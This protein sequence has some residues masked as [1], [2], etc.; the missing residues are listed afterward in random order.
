MASLPLATSVRSLSRLRQIVRVL[1]R[2]GFGHVVERINLGRF[3]PLGKLLRSE[4]S[5]PTETS[6]AS[7]GRRLASVAAELGP[8]FVKLAQM[9]STRPD[10][11]SP[12]VL[13][14]LRKLQDKVP[15]FDTDEAIRLI[16]EQ[17]GAPL[18]K[19]FS[20]FDRVPLASGSIG[21]VHLA[22]TT[23]DEDVVVK[24]KR[25]GIDDIV[26][27]DVHLLKWMAQAGENM[28][29][30]LSRLRPVQIVEEFEQL[31]N[32]ELDF[33]SEASATSR[34]RD[35]FAAE[36]YMNIPRVHWD[37]TGPGVLTM[38]RIRGENV[39]GVVQNG[40]TS[41]DRPLLA[42]RLVSIYLK[43]FFDMR[44]F[45]ADPHPGNFLILPPARIGL[46]DFGQVGTLSDEL[47]GQLVIIIVAMIYREP[48]VVVDVLNDL[49]AVGHDTDAR[50][51]ARA[52]RSLL[53]KYYG[54]P[55][56][57]LDLGVIFM[58]I[59]EVIRSHGV[60]L[61]REL[62]TVLKTLVTIS[63]VA[64]KLDP[65]LN[66]VEVMGPHVRKL[67]ADRFAPARLARTMTV[68]LW[69][70]WNILKSAPGQLRSVLRQ[71][72]RGTWQVNI[73]HENLDR[74]TDE[75][76]RS[77]NRMAFSIVIAA[78]IVGSSVVISATEDAVLLGMPLRWIGVAGYL[79]AGVLGVGLLWAIFRSGRLS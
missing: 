11:V 56:K 7:L 14:E 55:L 50:A 30:E 73:R 58:E 8:T 37:L 26:R 70:T 41:V 46:V 31:L 65:Q 79:F 33:I 27:N 54:L 49:G 52:L 42:R 48:Q 59:T 17:V 21:Q 53:D 20:H 1:A 9:I 51:L 67:L 64:L 39:E 3:L 68:S 28:V 57:R 76:D 71:I 60:T 24:V 35:A 69:H 25:P 22:R 44:L 47:A 45:H 16:E 61:P 12:E 5:A 74:L 15:P 77:S 2:H 40:D 10:L 38:S 62:V 75:L 13:A 18:D 4:P 34:F 72:G 23:G 43:Q 63:G 19:C 32:R 36:G 29:T 78:V 6:G 66:L